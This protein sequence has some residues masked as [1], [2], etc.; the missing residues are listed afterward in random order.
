MG[1]LT[2]SSKTQRDSN[3]VFLFRGGEGRWVS[4]QDSSDFP[5]QTSS[6]PRTIPEKP[7]DSAAREGASG[8]MRPEHAS[9]KGYLRPSAP[10]LA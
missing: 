6:Q 3:K 2:N 10:P 5:A 4:P 7:R 9:P 8:G 1:D